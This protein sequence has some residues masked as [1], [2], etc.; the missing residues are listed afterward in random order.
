MKLNKILTAAAIAVAAAGSAHAVPT[1][2]NVDGTLSPFGGFDWASG[3]AAFTTGFTGGVGSTFTMTYAAVAS[4]LTDLGS[5]TLY[6][7]KLDTN[8]NGT[9]V[10]AG[11]YEYTIFATLQETV[12]ACGSTICFLVTGGNFD[13]YYDTSANATAPIG[14][15][16]NFEDGT[17][18]VSGTVNAAAVAQAFQSTGGQAVLD[19]QVT[20]TNGAFINPQLVNTNFSS[21]LQLSSVTNFS[22]PTSIDGNIIGASEVVFQAD[23]NQTFTTAVPE[24]AG[25]ALVGLGLAGCGLFSRRRKS[26]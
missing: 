5:G 21:T 4:S 23:G 19:G 15:W 16:T 14:A 2:T 10:T 24:P 6:T 3:G 7:P 11:A 17:K 9:P 26:A 18:I 12:V 25:L 22:A 8:P 20:F 1:I 13:I